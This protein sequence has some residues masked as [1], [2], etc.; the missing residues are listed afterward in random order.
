MSL[1]QARSTPRKEGG[2][3]S[4][5]E[6]RFVQLKSW[7]L[8]E[9]SRAGV[10]PRTVLSRLERSMYPGLIIRRVNSR[11]VFIED[12]HPEPKFSRIRWS[13]GRIARHKILMRDWW[14]RRRFPQ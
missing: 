5:G 10:L 12:R 11:V 9:A 1:T 2:T 4:G 3:D 8:D 7:L 14:R 13:V 6:V